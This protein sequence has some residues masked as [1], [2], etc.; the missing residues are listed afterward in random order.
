MIGPVKQ[1]CIQKYRNILER[2]KAFRSHTIQK[3]KSSVIQVGEWVKQQIESFGKSIM[4]AMSDLTKRIQ[5]D[6]PYLAIA[7]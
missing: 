4:Q 2:I 1:I 3:I 7:L 6:V 5:G